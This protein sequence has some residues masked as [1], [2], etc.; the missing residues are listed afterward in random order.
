MGNRL[1]LSLK[2]IWSQRHIFYYY[3]CYYWEQASVC[4]SSS[5]R[6]SHRVLIL[7][8]L[9][10][11]NCH[12]ERQTPNIR[13]IWICLKTIFVV[14]LSASQSICPSAALPC[15]QTPEE[16]IIWMPITNVY[17]FSLVYQLLLYDNNI[18]VNVSTYFQYLCESA[19]VSVGV[20]ICV[21]VYVCAC[22]PCIVNIVN[23]L[24]SIVINIM[25][26][27]SNT[28]FLRR[29]GWK[30]PTWPKYRM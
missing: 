26:N 23:K 27:R 22:V 1:L 24:Q 3:Y 19:L 7:F 30:S 20:Y 6:P 16:I 2:F 18:I 13:S 25:T 9:A 28:N 12:H 8:N 21:C 11:I 10:Y 29:S 15:K 14:C 4:T 5:V 17:Y